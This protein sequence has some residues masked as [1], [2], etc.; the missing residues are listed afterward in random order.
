MLDDVLPLVRKPVRYTGGEYN[1]TIK[2]NPRVHIGLIF[3]EVYELGMSN[4]GIRIVYHL[5]NREG[6]VQCE[7]IFAPWPDFG[8]RIR[9]MGLSPYGL[10]TMRPMEDFDLLGFSLQ[11][12]LCYTTVLYILDLASLP[13]RSVDRTAQHPIL[14]AGGPATL[15]PRPLSY[16]FDAFV[17]GDGEPVIPKIANILK[18]TD[19]AD[20]R[21]R[22]LEMSKIEGVWV[23]SIHGYNTKIKKCV[24]AALDEEA[25]PFPPILP[26][27][28]ITHDRYVIEVMRG[29]TWGWATRRSGRSSPTS[30][31]SRP[32]RWGRPARRGPTSVTRRPSPA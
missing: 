13:L 20:K 10:E 1:I 2:K 16:V 14:I 7:R 17:I 3:P 24:A 30:S 4:L 8:D 12:E 29:C 6:D 9:D 22:L 19:K 23:P 21:E 26:I 32:P 11:S 25:L 18:N 15:N 27:C 31:C 28:E 5:F